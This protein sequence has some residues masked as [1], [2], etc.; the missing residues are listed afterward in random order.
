[1]TLKAPANPD[2]LTTFHGSIGVVKEGWLNPEYPEYQRLKSGSVWSAS[3]QAMIDALPADGSGAIYIP[4]REFLVSGLIPRTNTSMFGESWASCLKLNPAGTDPNV[5]RNKYTYQGG[6]KISN[7]KFSGFQIDGNKVA[8]GALAEF[9]IAVNADVV[10]ISDMWI[11]HTGMANILVG[12]NA[13]GNG[14]ATITNNLCESPGLS[15]NFWGAIAA[16]N[17]EDIVITG[18]NCI[19]GSDGFMAYGIDVEPN[20]PPGWTCRRVHIVGNK[21][22]KGYLTLAGATGG[23]FEEA[24]VMGNTIDASSSAG[25]GAA[26]TIRNITGAM[27]G[28]NKLIGPSNTSPVMYLDTL[29]DPTVFGGRLT[30]VGTAQNTYPNNVMVLLDDVTRG[31]IGGLHMVAG[32]ATHATEIAGIKETGTT[33]GVFYGVNHFRNVTQRGISRSNF[34]EALAETFDASTSFNI[35]GNAFVNGNRDAFLR[36]ILDTSGAEFTIRLGASALGFHGT[37]ATTKQTVAANA[38]DL[39][40]AITLVNDLKAKLIAK[41][42]VQ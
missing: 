35:L 29:T 3:F 37:A 15:G 2:D 10:H 13:D 32:A 33:A 24:L 16:T 36:N 6:A 41:G 4:P 5:I 14:R 22:H 25:L 1:M 8:K 9:G 42:L 18:N 40:T 19:N 21:I 28:P 12:D 20:A 39:A 26:L 38:S 11:H 23:I 27:I 7:V 17:G 30:G 34:Y 31:S